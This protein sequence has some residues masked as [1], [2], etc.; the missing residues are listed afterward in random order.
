MLK[1]QKVKKRKMKNN[2]RPMMKVL[3]RQWDIRIKMF[4]ASSPKAR[5]TSLEQGLYAITI[6]E[7]VFK[8]RYH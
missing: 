5:Q 3:K 1:G 8:R 2:A 6:L 4:L 7:D